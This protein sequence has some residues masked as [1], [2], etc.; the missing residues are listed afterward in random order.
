[1]QRAA[2]VPITVEMP[3]RNWDVTGDGHR[4]ARHHQNIEVSLNVWADY[5]RSSPRPSGAK[6]DINAGFGLREATLFERAP[7]ARPTHA[8]LALLAGLR[9]PA[10]GARAA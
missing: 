6:T 8:E 2:A 5:S 10:N 9:A 1:M 7:V 4:S 3:Q